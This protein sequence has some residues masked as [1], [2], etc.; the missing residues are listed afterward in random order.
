MLTISGKYTEIFKL[1]TMLENAE[2]MF[3][4]IPHFDYS[5]D[6]KFITEYS[7]LMGRYQICYPVFDPNYR[8]VSVIE[9]FGTFGSEEDKLEIMLKTKDDD[10][11]VIG[12][13]T[14]DAVFT[15]I[16]NHWDSICHS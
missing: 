11:G 7:D 16:K 4:W 10:G 12:H 13:L 9:G 1:K 15:M 8:I 3:D 5:E 14:A 2:I 6:D